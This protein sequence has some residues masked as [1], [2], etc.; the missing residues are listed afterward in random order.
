MPESALAG[1]VAM[2]SPN[3]RFVVLRFRVGHLPATDQRLQVYR[4]E[5]RVGEVRVA[6][7]QRDD[8]M[9]ADVLAGDCQVGDEVWDR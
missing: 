6:G 4:G 3:L 7:W 9:V 2:V 8:Y 1:K 5:L